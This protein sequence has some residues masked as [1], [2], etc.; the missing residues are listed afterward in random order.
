M[1]KINCS[2]L[3]KEEYENFI[4]Y[5]KENIGEEAIVK[6]AGYMKAKIGIEKFKPEEVEFILDTYKCNTKTNTVR[7]C[8]DKDIHITPYLLN[9]LLEEHNKGVRCGLSGYTK[10]EIEHILNIYNT[11]KNKANTIA[12]CNAQGIKLSRYLLGEIIKQNS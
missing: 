11:I 5:I 10:E 9:K 1:L 7:I 4:S 3:D 2:Q 8:G 6:S 12:L